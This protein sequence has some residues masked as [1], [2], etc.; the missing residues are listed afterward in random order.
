MDN[1][2]PE[3]QGAP[4]CGLYYR[5][6]AGA[7][8]ETV[9]QTVKEMAFVVNRASGYE[10]NM[11]VVQI[12]TAQDDKGELQDLIK[13]VQSMGFVAV[14]DEDIG[15]ADK[16]DADGV[17]VSGFKNLAKAN[18]AFEDNKIIGFHCKASWECA[19]S[20]LSE[21][22]DYVS[23]G[24][25]GYGMA[26]IKMIGKWTKM[27]VKPCAALGD[28]NNDTCGFFAQS[29]ASFVEVTKYIDT[30]DESVMKATINVLHALEL[31]AE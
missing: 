24:V 30:H 12:D 10:R 14:I 16:M 19:E 26:D 13:I 27:T 17:I 4:P 5:I 31:A 23:F 18:S 3:K 6:G 21:G 1:H 2:T 8:I 29:G 25:G 9:T 28:F 20:A 11:N 7:D 22:I 15:I